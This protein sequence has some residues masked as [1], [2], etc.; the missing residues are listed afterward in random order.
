MI[1][2]NGIVESDEKSFKVY[3]SNKNSKNIKKTSL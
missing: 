3:I 1:F 2:E